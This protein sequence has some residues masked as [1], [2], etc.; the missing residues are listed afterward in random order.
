MELRRR[1]FFF[2]ERC[3]PRDLYKDVVGWDHGVSLTHAFP[4]FLL[5]I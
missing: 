1:L 2:L 5:K 4:Y 3:G